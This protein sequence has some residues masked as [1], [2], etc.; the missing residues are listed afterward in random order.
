[1]N[2]PPSRGKAREWRANLVFHE[3]FG[4][5]VGGWSLR[6]SGKIGA[7]GDE[8][9]SALVG[10]V[11]PG[12]LDEN[13]DAVAEADEEKDVDEEPGEPGEESGDVEFAEVGDS[14]GAADGGERAFVPVVK[15]GAGEA[16]LR[17]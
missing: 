14:G 15:G 17:M 12:P 2:A 1:M 9:G 4:F 7:A 16:L 3:G 5:R 8:A 10:E 6:P 13:Q 11:R